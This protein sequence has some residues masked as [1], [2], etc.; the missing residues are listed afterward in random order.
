M[1]DGLTTESV[2]QQKTWTFCFCDFVCICIYLC[3]TGSEACL[4]EANDLKDT[5]RKHSRTDPKA[6]LPREWLGREE[7]SG[8]RRL[9]PHSNI[10]VENHRVTGENPQH[11]RRFIL[12]AILFIR[13]KLLTCPYVVVDFPV[14]KNIIR[15]IATESHWLFCSFE[16][17]YSHVRMWS[18]IFLLSKTSFE[19]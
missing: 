1:W 11:S 4:E 8:I 3:F 16:P 19:Q 12:W 10:P 2:V 6:R 15:A 7:S 14:V 18:W 17:S 9:V 5:M 13:T